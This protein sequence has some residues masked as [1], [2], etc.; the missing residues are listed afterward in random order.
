[1]DISTISDLLSN[2]GF[3]MVCV[4]GLSYF[5]WA[6][7]QQSVKRE[8]KLMSVNAQAIETISKYAD[9]LTVIE[10]DVKDIKKDLGIL[11]TK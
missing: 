10:D 4:I 7:Y 3:P 6:L 8:E 11:L 9:K 2:F 5:V 1:M